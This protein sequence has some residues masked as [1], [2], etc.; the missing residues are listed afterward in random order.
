MIRVM[1]EG[2]NGAGITRL[3]DQLCESVRQASNG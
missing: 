1:A 3:V 2:E